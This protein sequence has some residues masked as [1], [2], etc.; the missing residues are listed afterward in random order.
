MYSLKQLA[1]KCRYELVCNFGGFAMQ[2]TKTMVRVGW[3][4]LSW[5]AF[6][7]L[8]CSD[9]Q[10]YTSATSD[11]A[12]NQDDL[13]ICNLDLAQLCG[14]NKGD[15]LAEVL[16]VAAASDPSGDEEKVVGP[17]RPPFDLI[18]W[19]SETVDESEEA[20][21]PSVGEEDS[22]DEGEPDAPRLDC[23]VPGALV[24][25][26]IMPDPA[27]VADT[28]GE[29]FEITSVIG[30]PI[31]LAGWTITSQG[32]TFQIP[33]DESFVVGDGR[34]FVFVAKMDPGKNGGIQG[35]LE[36]S[37]IRLGNKAGNIALWCEDSLIDQVAWDAVT[38]PLAAGRA[39]VLDPAFTD[40]VLNDQPEYWCLESEVFSSGDRGSPGV[41][42]KRCGGNS[43]G[44]KVHQVWEDC[45]DGN[46]LPGDG[47]DAK[48]K[49]ESFEVG[50]VVITEFHHTPVAGGSNGEFVELKNMT[51]KPIDIAGWEL[52][53]AKRDRVRILPDSGSLVIEPQG[54]LVLAKNG[55]PKVNGGFAP[56]WVYGGRFTMAAPNDEIIL[57]WN[58]TVIDEVRYEIGVNDWPAA[59]GASVNLDVSCID[60]EFN[61]WGFFWCATWADHRLPGGD[62]ATPGTTN[63][64]C[65]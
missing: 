15:D 26:E 10:G 57:S 58:G 40:A 7:M 31:D 64:T 42:N 9:Y 11:N 13:G 46:Q 1:W 32:K 27:M 34:T 22:L 41:K 52:S 65:P 61:D 29:Y 43:C 53:D 62:A 45:E 48:C 51:D 18:D 36:W 33:R 49:I 28:D 8:G 2:S 5:L 19:E 3:V 38:W 37:A 50:S 59:K 47:C 63:H 23:P 6:M 60:H 55:D 54:L 12:F 39:L 4:F 20:G 30:D 35:D 44:D 17:Q 16:E 24:I 21:E 14:P 25:T 56:D